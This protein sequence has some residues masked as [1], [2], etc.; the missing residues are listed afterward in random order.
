MLHNV[1]FGF[2]ETYLLREVKRGLEEERDKGD[3]G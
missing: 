2:V 3:E 1:A